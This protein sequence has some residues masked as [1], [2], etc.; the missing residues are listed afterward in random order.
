M[1]GTLVRPA[2]R[3]FCGNGS[4]ATGILP[5]IFARWAG[6]HGTVFPT[7]FASLFSTELVRSM[8]KAKTHKGMAKRFKVTGSGT[9]ASHRSANR[10]HILGK[11]SAKRKRHLRN[12]GI[13]SG[14]NARMIVDALRPSM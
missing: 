10:G 7:L 1:S 14:T 4:A 13:V 8:P 12:G 11:K 2:R 6:F 5:E 3:Q 9:K